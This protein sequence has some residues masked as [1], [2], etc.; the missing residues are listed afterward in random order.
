MKEWGRRERER[1]GKRKMRR[2]AGREKRR[3]ERG[4]GRN[5]LRLMDSDTHVHGNTI[6]ICLNLEKAIGGQ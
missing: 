3:A 2:R 6:I 5:K 4:E 1:A